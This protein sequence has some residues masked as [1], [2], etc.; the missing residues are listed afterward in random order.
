ML[1]MAK[2]P[3][4]DMAA[5]KAISG[6]GGDQAERRGR[7]IL[8]AV[9]RGLEVPERD[10]PRVE[11]PPRRAF[12]PA[13]E[14]RLERLKA[15][16]NRLAAE[17]DL[18][19]GVLCPNGTLEAIARANPLNLDQLAQV[20]DLRRWQLQTLGPELLAALPEPLAP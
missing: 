9:Q 4:A 17:L 15:V 13:L 7:E 11:R 5:L 12:D 8:A 19:P 1:T 10:L 2:S 20:P 16:R 18:A 3:P 6:I 14:S